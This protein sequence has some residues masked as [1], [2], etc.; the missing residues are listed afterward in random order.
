MGSSSRSKSGSAN[1]TA[2]SATRMRQPPEN[3]PQGRACSACG[4]TQACEDFGRARGR[5]MGSDVGE[6]D[7]DLRD[8][9]RI[10]FG[11]GLGEEPRALGVGREDDVEQALRAVRRLL[12]EAPD[13]G[14]RG[15]RKLAALQ[16]HL[17]ADD[18]EQG[19]LAGA[20]AADEADAGAAGIRTEAASIRSDPAT[21][22]ERLS[23]TSMR[24]L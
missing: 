6:P 16:R 7:L 10:A 9:M 1:S 8:P 14:A 20:I 5:R 2:A 19:G 17:T 23:I 4:E 11:L 18:A 22:T 21:R 3:S 15:K 24:A 12:G 13:A